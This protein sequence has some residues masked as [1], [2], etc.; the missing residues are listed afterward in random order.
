VVPILNNVTSHLVA[1]RNIIRDHDLTPRTVAS[2]R[3]WGIHL[4]SEGSNGIA[5][6]NVSL[7]AEVRHNRFYNNRMGLN[8]V[9]I[10]TDDSDNIV[11]SHSNIYDSQIQSA[12]GIP[13]IGT[14]IFTQIS[15]SSANTHRSRN[16]LISNND[17][18]VNNVG[19]GGV[20]ALFQAPSGNALDESEI[21]LS[22]V[23][24]GKRADVT[25]IDFPSPAGPNV[26]GN[27]LTILLRQT[28]TSS[29][30][31]PTD[32]S[33]KPFVIMDRADVTPDQVSWTPK[34]RQVAKV[35]P[36]P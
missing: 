32:P 19:N 12:G 25:L 28:S 21:N 6:S 20:L 9:N 13:G 26:S 34:M 8:V 29:A 5:L 2:S 23:G 15:S 3:G 30:P 31:I 11:I 14:G 24:T 36:C 22:F 7:S 27:R 10:G 17:T 33:P 1:E 18:I 4:D 16:K 35:G